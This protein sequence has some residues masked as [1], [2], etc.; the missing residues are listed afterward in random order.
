M[1]S[2]ARSLLGSVFK[3]FG[4]HLTKNK[5]TIFC[6][7]D[8]SN[9]PGEFS[10][11]YNLNVSPNIF[12]YQIK[13]IKENFN[14]ISP[15]DLLAN[16]IPK[17]AALITFDDGYKSYF[18]SAIPL[19][20]KYNLPSLIFLNM[21][22]VN[23]DIFLSGL[24]TYL[25][26]KS[27]DFRNHIF[28]NAKCD[29][30][31]KPLHLYCSREIVNSFIELKG[32]TFRDEVEN[33]V[34]DFATKKDLELQSSNDL[35]FFG[36]HLYNHDVSLLLSDEELLESFNRNQNEL[37]K[38]PCSRNLFAFPFGQ[39][40]TCFS[41]RQ[42]DLLICNGALKVFSS[43]PLVNA[44]D[45]DQYLHRIPLTRFNNTKSRIWFKILRKSFKI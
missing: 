37:K 18:E 45:N 34:G 28:L 5:L 22:P 20:K 35:V 1:K 17:H 12:E 31:K 11:K 30:D 6:Y 39:P 40:E 9:S 36:N 41:K 23:G 19:L 2:I 13:F 33:F 3:P 27:S 4:K 29:L 7:H 44:R 15:D 32:D 25:C 42:I 24:V 16:K 8:V 38:Y 14:V 10:E 21:A 43:Y 26:D